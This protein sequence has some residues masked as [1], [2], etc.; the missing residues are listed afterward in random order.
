MTIVWRCPMTAHDYAAAGR[1]IESDRPDCPSCQKAM[2]FHGFYSR[3]L[4]IGGEIL[5]LAIRRA[6]C[7]ACQVT[8]GLVPDFVGLLRLDAV[9]VIG[10]ALEQMITGTAGAV[11]AAGARVPYTTARDWRRR[12][13]ARAKTLA[14]GFLAAVVAL[15]D[16]VG[17]VPVGDANAALFAIGALAAADHRRFGSTASPWRVANRIVGGHLLSANTDPP[18]IVS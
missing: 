12:F 7:R 13:L 14:S 16:L 6:R 15:G 8:H 10:D 17:G 11:A 1:K 9:E 3:P 2:S 4:R 5:R 18:W